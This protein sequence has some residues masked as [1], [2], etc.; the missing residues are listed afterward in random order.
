MTRD[1]EFERHLREARDRERAEHG[2]DGFGLFG[3]ACLVLLFFS[4][5]LLFV[6]YVL[7]AGE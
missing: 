7:G 3:A 4:P 5:V 6:S 2:Q 1:E